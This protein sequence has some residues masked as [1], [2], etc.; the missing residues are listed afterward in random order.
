MRPRALCIFIGLYG[1]ALLAACGIVINPDL[2]V[3][4]NGDDAGVESDGK[5]PRGDGA[6]RDDADGVVDPSCKPTGEEI[7]DDGI[8]N[9]CNGAIDCADRACTDGF[10][11][12]DPPPEGWTSILVADDKRPPCPAAYTTPTD[13]RVVEGDGAATC[14]C[15]CGNN[16]G[17]TITLTK[18]TEATCTTVSSTDTFQPNTTKCTGKAFD[19]ASGFTVATVDAGACTPTDTTTKDALTDGR[20]CTPRSSA[21]AGCEGAQRCIPKASGFD[22]CIAKAG[23]AVCP[24]SGFTNQRRSGTT[25][26]DQRTCVGCSCSS[27]P[28]TVALDLWTHPTCQGS[29]NLEIT[30]V[31]AAN[32]FLN[33]VKAYQTKATSGCT[34]ATP[35]VPHG[36]I[37]FENEQ[38]ICCR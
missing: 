33:N 9:D 37:D 32:D 20:T 2:L 5:T 19:L 6:S 31:C 22:V 8:D 16:C 25:A 4:G 18:A 11:C 27:S 15:D 34:Q 3:A 26:N 35:S 17:A 23:G 12:V 29:F 24:S 13:V 38:T 36:A 30:S 1:A 21:A 7:C 14:A 28:C 10:A